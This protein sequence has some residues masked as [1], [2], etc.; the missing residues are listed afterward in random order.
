[1]RS[2]GATNKKDDKTSRPDDTKPEWTSETIGDAGQFVQPAAAQLTRAPV[3]RG[4]PIQQVGRQ[5]NGKKIAQGVV[6]GMKIHAG[7]V[8]RDPV[9]TGA[10]SIEGHGV[11]FRCCFNRESLPAAATATAASGP[12]DAA[13]YPFF[14][15]QKSA[16]PLSTSVTLR[17][18][19][20]G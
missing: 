8:G 14:R 9:R 12:N 15:F 5:V 6:G 10:R 19:A 3:M 4:Q 16:Y 13:R 2:I 17:R 18:N 20:V 7:A 1:M 11:S